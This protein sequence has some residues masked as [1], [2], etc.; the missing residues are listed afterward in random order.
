MK[1]NR[2][3][4]SLVRNINAGLAVLLVGAPGVGKTD[5]VHEVARQTER[6]LLVSHP[7]VSDPTDAKGLPYPNKKGD[8]ARFLPYGVMAQALSAT[9]PTLWFL[10]DLGQAAPAVQ[11]A[12]MQLLLARRIDE[13][14]LPNCVTFVA[15]TNRK[16]DR[17]GVS[18]LLEP[19]KSRFVTILEVEPDLD[20]WIDWALAK[21]LPPELVAFLQFRGGDLFHKPNPTTELVNSP[22][23]RTWHNLAKLLKAGAADDLKEDKAGVLEEL[24]G[25]VGKEAATEFVNFLEVAKDLPSLDD[26]LL[27]PDTA[28]IPDEVS[29]L[30]VLASG[31]A[32]AATKTNFGALSTYAGRMVQQAYG[33]AAAFMVRKSIVLTP[34]I[35]QTAAYSRLLAGEVGA[36]L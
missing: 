25:S 2:V 31:L 29:T 8:A 6:E 1:I 27:Y 33:E 28:R 16:Q 21:G 23:P 10:D 5:V 7:V 15:A 3:R 4:Q 30:W 11:A 26:V 22:S 18:G 19:V 9:K 20:M 24:S 13:H 34:G 12:F 17:A 36:L 32:S 35:T 14:A